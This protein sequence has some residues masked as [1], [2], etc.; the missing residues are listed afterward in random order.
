MTDPFVQS[1]LRA[2]QVFNIT[3]RHPVPVEGGKDIPVAPELSRIEQELDLG[4]Y[5]SG[6][7]V[8]LMPL[9]HNL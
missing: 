3:E 1:T 6:G 4:Y 5:N 2:L 8:K 7:K 9:R